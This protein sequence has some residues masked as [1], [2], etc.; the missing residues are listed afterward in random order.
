MKP[1]PTLY[2]ALSCGRPWVLGVQHQVVDY[3]GLG[4]ASDVLRLLVNALEPFRYSTGAISMEL[5]APLVQPPPPGVSLPNSDGDDMAAADGFSINLCGYGIGEQV[6]GLWYNA[7]LSDTDALAGGAFV[8]RD[9]MFVCTGI[10][11]ETQQ[12]FQRGGTGTSPTDP[13]M[14]SS[15]LSL[16]PPPKGSDYSATIQSILLNYMAI[17]I[18][19]GDQGTFYRTG[20]MGAYPQMGGPR[21]G[22]SIPN[23]VTGYPGTYIPFNSGISFGSKDDLNNLTVTCTIGQTPSTSTGSISG[24]VGVGSGKGGFRVQ[25]SPFNPTV[26]GNIDKGG[27][28]P[29]TNGTINAA[30]DGTVYAPFRL[31]FMGYPICVPLPNYCGVPELSP[32]EVKTLQKALGTIGNAVPS[33]KG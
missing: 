11:A 25:S 22:S 33:Q 21:G 12:P 4:V 19:F 1:D 27:P 2:Q 16:P 13:K 8:P 23:G 24:K 17:Q 14:Y 15:W 31:T 29:E 20:V 30:N 9:F 5:V 6:A 3:C 32:D 26:S 18:Q 7:T 28:N 10:T